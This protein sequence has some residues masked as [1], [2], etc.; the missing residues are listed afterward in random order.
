M[1]YQGEASFQFA[2]SPIYYINLIVKEFLGTNNFYIP[3]IGIIPTDISTE[4]LRI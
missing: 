3:T 4:N 2:V 1:R